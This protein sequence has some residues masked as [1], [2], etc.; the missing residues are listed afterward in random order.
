MD[1]PDQADSARPLAAG[2]PLT[3]PDRTEAGEYYFTYID[4]VP[5]GDIRAILRAQVDDVVPILRGISEERSRHRY[6]SGKW[7][8]REVLGHVNDAERVFAYRAF[9]FARGF[10]SP[11]PSFDQDI[12]VPTAA[13][14]KRSWSSHIDEFRTVR[15]ATV[16]LFQH[17]PAEAWSR[18]G[19]ASNQPVT[20]NALAYIIAGH[21]AHHVQIL[22]ER[23]LTG[24]QA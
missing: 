16:D 24:P 9:W 19:I 4:K 3:P 2:V 6:A 15:S 10:E 11:L 18:R 13:A 17:L 14:D 12:A 1:L 22:T 8:I 23:Y 20:V 5:V 7:S 21:L